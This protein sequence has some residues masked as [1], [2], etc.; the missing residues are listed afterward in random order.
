MPTDFHPPPPPHIHF[1]FSYASV[2][3]L[4]EQAIGYVL[5]PLLH[6]KS[7]GPE[8]QQARAAWSKASVEYQPALAHR[9]WASRSFV[10]PIFMVFF[11]VVAMVA[12]FAT[13]VVGELSHTKA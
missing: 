4:R 9:L 6:M 13:A 11:G 3:R 8:L 12:G 7:N 2:N 5:P 1:I 10:V